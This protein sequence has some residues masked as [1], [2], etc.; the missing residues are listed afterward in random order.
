MPDPP[1]Y[2]SSSD[3]GHSL[4]INPLLGKRSDEH[5]EL[6][7]EFLR[8]AEEERQRIGQGIHDGLGSLL[9]GISMM[10]AS[11]LRDAR[12][13]RPVDV[14]VLEELVQ[15]AREGVDQARALA[16]GLN[17]VRSEDRNLPAA[18]DVLLSD[19]QTISGTPY[20]FNVGDLSALTDE[21]STQFFWLVREALEGAVWKQGIDRVAVDLDSED[22][23]VSLRI[24]LHGSAARPNRPSVDGRTAPDAADLS[25]ADHGDVNGRAAVDA[26]RQTAAHSA[27]SRSPLELTRVRMM[28]YRT[29]LI[30]GTLTIEAATDSH[31]TIVCRIPSDRATQHH[32]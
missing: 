28:A 8:S 16:R 6:E 27:P 25:T 21:V 12:E 18:L 26:R 10:G 14:D 31:L 29:E 7:R 5:R 9:S 17:P 13:G 15:I 23:D 11:L 24:T 30:G 1:E 19:H 32:N 22:G 20:T 3:A 4:R 2:A